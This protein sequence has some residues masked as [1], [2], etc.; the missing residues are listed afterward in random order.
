VLKKKNYEKKKKKWK[1]Y[2]KKFFL[3]K[4]TVNPLR[5][6]NP[7]HGKKTPIMVTDLT[8]N[9]KIS[10]V[11]LSACIT[12]KACKALAVLKKP[13]KKLSQ[14]VTPKIDPKK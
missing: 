3:S 7:Y 14:K 6:K 5:K 10:F 9:C 12:C 11:V 4:T 2:L 13:P 8:Y 1:K